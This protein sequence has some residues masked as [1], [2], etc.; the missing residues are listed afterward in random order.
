[1]VN[2]PNAKQFGQIHFHD[3]GDYLSQAQKLEIIQELESIKGISDAN[4][5]SSIKPDEFGDWVNQRDPNFDNY[6]SLGDKKDKSNPAVFENYSQGVLTSRDAWCYNFSKCKL[7]S[8]LTGM[9]S[10]YSTEM[11]KAKLH[12]LTS[13]D[14]QIDKNP[15]H[16]SWSGNL[17][18]LFDKAK[19]LSLED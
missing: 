1:M 16:I 12:G 18:S 9:L 19:A 6:I 17:K 8:N 15:S 2:N 14:V 7:E 5:W 11:S 13:E 10:T 3:I 4:G